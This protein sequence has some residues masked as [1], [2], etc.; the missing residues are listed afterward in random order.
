MNSKRETHS[1]KYASQS[2][3]NLNHRIVIVAEKKGDTVCIST[4]RTQNE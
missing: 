4:I 1:I 2:S 3:E